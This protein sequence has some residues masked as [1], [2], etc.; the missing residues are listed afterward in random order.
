MSIHDPNWHV[1]PIQFLKTELQRAI[2]ADELRERLGKSDKGCGG[3]HQ[4]QT[5]AQEAPTDGDAASCET[6]PRGFTCE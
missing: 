2:K 6:S 3:S 1:S 5:L 4:P